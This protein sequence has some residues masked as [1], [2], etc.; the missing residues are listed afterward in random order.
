MRR[1]MLLLPIFLFA[2]AFMPIVSFASLTVVSI[3]D[4]AI[5]AK[6]YMKPFQRPNVAT[7]KQY[8]KLHPNI[9]GFYAN[10]LQKA[11]EPNKC[12]LTVGPVSP[13]FIPS[14]KRIPAFFIIDGTSKSLA[15]LKQNSAVLA[16]EK[17]KGFL[18]NSDLQEALQ[19]S[20]HYK[21]SI[22]P[23]SCDGLSTVV[24]TT[25]IPLFVKAG[26]VTR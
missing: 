8:I 18:I 12:Q 13:H 20:H 24:K 10:R 26:W 11:V 14:L 21:L 9:N 17:V 22:L 5:S 25:H 4:N 6:P 15:W 23:V 19:L 3:G 16:K 1:L 2:I 7:F